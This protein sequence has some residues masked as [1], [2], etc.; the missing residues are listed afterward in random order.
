[1]HVS[2]VFEKLILIKLLSLLIF[3]YQTFCGFVCWHDT[4]ALECEHF[5]WM[6]FLACKSNQSIKQLFIDA[7]EKFLRNDVLF[8]LPVHIQILANR[9]HDIVR[10]EMVRGAERKPY[11]LV[12]RQDENDNFFYCP[13]DNHRP[14][15]SRDATTEY[16]IFNFLI[17]PVFAHFSRQKRANPVDFKLCSGSNFVEFV[18]TVLKDIEHLIDCVDHLFL[19][20]RGY[21]PVTDFELRS[22]TV[23]H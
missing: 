15:A 12:R 19:E 23:W 13:F 1:M 4:N 3:L 18:G 22:A 9:L 2:H 11:Q 21:L 8:D 7:R 16:K 6:C 17:V 5:V 14:A 20:I 10:F